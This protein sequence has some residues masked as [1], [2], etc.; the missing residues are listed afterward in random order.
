MMVWQSALEIAH[1]VLAGDTTAVEQTEAVREACERYNRELGAFVALNW[2]SALRQAA[3]VDAEIAEGEHPG[4]FAG[5]PFGVKDLQHA[6]GFVTGRGSRL[7]LGD[8]PVTFD[9]P[10]VA[11]LRGAG[12]IPVGKTATAE[13]GMDSATTTPAYGTARNP[14]NLELTP[15]GSSGGTAAAVSAGIV[16][17]GTGTDEG[18]SI[19]SPASFCGLV[20]LKSTHGLV[21][22]DD[23]LSD[24]NSIGVLTRT[25][26]DSAALLDVIAGSHPADKMTQSGKRSLSYQQA[27]KAARVEIVVRMATR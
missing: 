17:F 9:S 27:M 7:H 4:P 24:T 15:G 5:V 21:P 8:E 22:R 16:P 3:A 1:S 2:D 6:A 20:G 18:G 13:F 19:R 14:W 10:S 25:V 12:A 11:R 26:A 23:G